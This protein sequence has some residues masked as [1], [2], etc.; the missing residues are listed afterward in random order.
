MSELIDIIAI[1]LIRFFVNIRKD[2]FFN[3]NFFFC[4]SLMMNLML[5]KAVILC[6]RILFKFFKFFLRRLDFSKNLKYFFLKY[7]LSLDF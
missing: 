2:K 5:K 3:I 6:N 4:S 7:F 1:F